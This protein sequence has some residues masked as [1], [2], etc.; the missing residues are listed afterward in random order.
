M[1]LWWCKP[2]PAHTRWQVR[3]T[4]DWID[5]VADHI[6]AYSNPTTKDPR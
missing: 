3:T 5:H 4:Q 6:K 2:C 1:H